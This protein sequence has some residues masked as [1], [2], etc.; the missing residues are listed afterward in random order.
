MSL[1]RQI[2]RVTIWRVSD[3]IWIFGCSSEPLLLQMTMR[4]AIA[5]TQ[6]SKLILPL[7]VNMR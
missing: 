3:G 7:R 2:Q 1:Q 4:A 5:K 6:V